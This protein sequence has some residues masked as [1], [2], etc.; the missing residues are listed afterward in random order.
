MRTPFF[1]PFSGIAATVGGSVSQHSISHGSGTHG[2]SA[3]SV[4]AMDIVTADGG[5]LRTGAA[6]RGAAPFARWYGP[7]FAGLFTGDC[8]V[9]GVK[10][11]I[12]LVLR[13]RLPAFECA[14]YAF[15]SLPQLARA[16]RAA[17]LEGLDDEH[18]AMDAAL[19]RGQ[20][21]RAARI[22]KFTTARDLARS[23]GSPFAA[24][25]QLVRSGL[26]GSRSLAVAAYSAH[27]IMEGIDAGEA[28]T[29]A[30]RLKRLMG[31]SG[32][33]PIAN[34]VPAV[35]RSK[36]FAPLFNT[37]GPD[38]ERWVPAARLPASFTGR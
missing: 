2:I 7:D 8:G 30:R 35:A 17:A 37:L 14:S 15:D 23:A 29:K 28:R 34:T 6:A 19:T 18:F 16:L 4:I 25:R 22:S 21:A 27:F 20:I 32:G 5:L 38:G 12:T 31:E 1:G 3:Q 33:R 24:L 11:R 10:A 26:A 36:P 13:R 9:F